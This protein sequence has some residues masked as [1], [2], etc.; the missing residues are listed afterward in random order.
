ME[1]LDDNGEPIPGLYAAGAEAMGVIFNDAY[2]AK[3]GAL[4]YSL[5]SGYIAGMEAA[6][7]VRAVVLQSCT[8]VGSYFE[9]AFRPRIVPLGLYYRKEKQRTCSAV[10]QWLR[11]FED[12]KLSSTSKIIKL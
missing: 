4:G 7:A 3:G 2:E 6:R 10:F 12:Y 8:S 11:K 1:V 9:Q 5:T